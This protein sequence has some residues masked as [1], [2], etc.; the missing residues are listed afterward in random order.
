MIKLEAKVILVIW[1]NS[2]ISARRTST[3]ESMNNK[4]T[5]INKRRTDFVNAV[6]K[7]K[8]NLKATTECE[9]SHLFSGIL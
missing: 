9:L 8:E 1:R 4:C 3:E 6:A 7:E 5:N 2:L